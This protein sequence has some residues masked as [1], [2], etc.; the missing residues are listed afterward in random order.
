MGEEGS[1]PSSP[2]WGTPHPRS[3]WGYPIKSW[4]G[5]TPGYPQPRLWMG[6]P[7]SAEWGTPLPEHLGWDSPLP[8]PGMGY[9]LPISWMVYPPP[10]WK[11]EQRDTCE[12]ST[13]PRTSYAGD[14]KLITLPGWD[15]NQ[16]NDMGIQ[17]YQPCVFVKNSNRR[18]IFC[19]WFWIWFW[20]CIFAHDGK[21]NL[22]FRAPS[23]IF[24]LMLFLLSK[25]TN[26]AMLA[27]L[28]TL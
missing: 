20:N 27:L 24:K 13:F 15:V 7:L 16:C 25:Y 11:C 18:N 28:P 23:L 6:Y 12:N 19:W 14:N 9:Y 4:T 21:K 5:G 8:G 17:S 3:G 26:L 22:P 2:G 1:T 10:S